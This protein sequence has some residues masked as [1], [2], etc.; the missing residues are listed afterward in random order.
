MSNVE[1]AKYKIWTKQIKPDEL[2]YTK[3]AAS[4]ENKNVSF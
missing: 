3:I 2:L 4:K 1:S